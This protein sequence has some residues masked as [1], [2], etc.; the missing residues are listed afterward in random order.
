M[1]ACVQ[2]PTG[3]IISGREFSCFLPRPKSTG[4]V[5]YLNIEK[6]LDDTRY[7]Y[8][9]LKIIRRFI[10]QTISRCFFHLFIWWI[11]MR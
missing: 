10:P 2:G 8:A 11:E 4:A 9:I 3:I 6:F 5:K 7:P 1:F